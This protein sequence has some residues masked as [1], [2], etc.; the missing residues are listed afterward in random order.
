M[1]NNIFYANQIYNNK[2]DLE[3][4]IK[5]DKIKII[6]NNKNEYL[7]LNNSDKNININEIWDKK[8]LF[9]KC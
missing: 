8:I 1:Q 6:S 2:N 3:K 9:C 7:E 5:S 4:E